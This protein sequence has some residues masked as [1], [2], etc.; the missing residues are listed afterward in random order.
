[1]K[2]EAPPRQ[3]PVSITSPGTSSRMIVSSSC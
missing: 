1:M 3:T 2:I